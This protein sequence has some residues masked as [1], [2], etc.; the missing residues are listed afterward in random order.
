M[1]VGSLAYVYAMYGVIMFYYFARGSGAVETGGKISC[2]ICALVSSIPYGC[3]AFY[4]QWSCRKMVNR[5]KLNKTIKLE[6]REQDREIRQEET[7]S[8]QQKIVDPKY[9]PKAIIDSFTD[10]TRA[11]SPMILL[12]F[13]TESVVL[14]SSGFAFS[15]ILVTN[16]E[17][18][19]SELPYE[20]YV[21][22]RNFTM[23][24]MFIYCAAYFLSVSWMA[25]E[26]HTFV[27]EFGTEVR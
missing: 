9:H 8:K 13:A 3:V 10:L 18:V 1:V 20:F 26:T 11:W 25:E 2:V 4:F 27:K 24:F 14:I 12:T 7:E 15:N 16:L 21:F 23:V 6:I 5:I 22:V 19:E 17:D